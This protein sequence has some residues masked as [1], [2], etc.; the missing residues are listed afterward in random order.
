MCEG[1]NVPH[2]QVALVVLES[3]VL[4]HSWHLHQ[5]N[6]FEI[7]FKETICQI[8]ISGNFVNLCTRNL[9]EN[10]SNWQLEIRL[11][12]ASN[13]LNHLGLANGNRS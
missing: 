13:I 3:I 12:Q 1:V 4:L 9:L 8:G 2:I 7:N 5:T 6:I 11:Q 10:M